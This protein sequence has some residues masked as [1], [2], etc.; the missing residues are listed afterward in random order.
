MEVGRRN[1]HIPQAG[2][3]RAIGDLG[4]TSANITT[5]EM[6]V[7]VHTTMVQELPFGARQLSRSDLAAFRPLFAHYLD[8]QKNLDINSIDETELRGRWKSFM[9]KWN[10]GELAEGWY[11]PE[12]FQRA[13]RDYQDSSHHTH[14]RPPSPSHVSAPRSNS[15]NPASSRFAPPSSKTQQDQQDDDDAEDDD[16]GPL[17]PPR[18]TGHPPAAVST[19]PTLSS[20][21]SASRILTPAPGPTIPTQADLSLRDEALAAARESEL[22]ALRLARRAHRREQKALLD[23]ALPP[24]AD[25][26]TRERRL[27]KRREVNE[28]MRGFREKSPIGE[29]PE[30]ELLGG[31]G[32]AEEE[33]RAMVRAREEK[34]K[35][36]VSRREEAERARRAEREERV[37]GLREREARVVE[38]LRELARQRF[39]I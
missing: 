1:V 36:R 10:R 12:V 37:R 27:E 29:V 20:S 9:G 35:E 7:R 3:E 32:T 23:E 13:A 15:A 18:K 11:D 22:A 5:T 30:G 8:L 19:F 6:N 16:Y 31:G 28:K 24:R 2:M 33:Y 4:V 14:D 38:G 34:R 25:A 26:G 39:G 21:S 17:P